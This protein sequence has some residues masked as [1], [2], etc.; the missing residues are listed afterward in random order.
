MHLLRKVS[1]AF[2]PSVFPDYFFSRRLVCD[3]KFY[4]WLS[5]PTPMNGITALRKQEKEKKKHLEK[6]VRGF[7]Q[8]LFATN[9]YGEGFW[10]WFSEK[11]GIK[12]KVDV[13][14]AQARA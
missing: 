6:A 12:K 7:N 13:R 10:K 5:L 14:T 9:H 11:C 4:S 3:R 1:C 8:V 2:F